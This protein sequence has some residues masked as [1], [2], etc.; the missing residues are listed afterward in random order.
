M[1][2]V[3]AVRAIITVPGVFIGTAVIDDVA[4]IVAYNQFA[5][6]AVIEA[7]NDEVVVETIPV[8]GEDVGDF[9]FH[10]L[11]PGH[12]LRI[13]VLDHRVFLLLTQQSG[14]VGEGEI[15]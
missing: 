14:L 5:A 6:H 1:I 8:G 2:S 9:D 4:A 11:A 3:Y 13:H 7:E 10:G 15:G 12:L